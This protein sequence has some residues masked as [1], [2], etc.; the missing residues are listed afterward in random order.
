LVFVLKAPASIP[1]PSLKPA[2]EKSPGDSRRTGFIFTLIP[3]I[4]VHVDPKVQCFI[5]SKIQGEAG[6]KVS[7]KDQRKELDEAADGEVGR[8]NWDE[9]LAGDGPRKRW[10]AL[11]TWKCMSNRG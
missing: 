2:N 4:H 1:Y 3:R 9:A 5:L 7:T 11:N 8:S 10:A 6:S